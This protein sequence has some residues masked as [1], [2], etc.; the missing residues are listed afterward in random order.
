[1]TEL[2]DMLLSRG[3]KR[4]LIDDN[5]E[6]A[7]LV[8]RDEA[9]KRKVRKKDMDRVVFSVRVEVPPLGQIDDQLIIAN[10]GL[11]SALAS[12]H[13]NAMTNVKTLQ[14]GSE[15]CVKMQIQLEISW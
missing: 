2:R 9:I 15:K 8:P 12:A 14:F 6:K 4:K 7:L 5:I 11:D 10:C 13:V 1:M 3:Y